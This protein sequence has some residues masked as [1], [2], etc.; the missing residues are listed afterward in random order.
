[1]S[2][3]TQGIAWSLQEADLPR[4]LRLLRAYP[5]DAAVPAIL[6]IQ[7]RLA[8]WLDA[9]ADPNSHMEGWYALHLAVISGDAAVLGKLAPQLAG[10]GTVEARLTRAEFAALQPRIPGLR[11]GW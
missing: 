11:R 2:D 5:C 9:G 4:A 1:M 3:A 10:I 7:G 6:G 8:Q